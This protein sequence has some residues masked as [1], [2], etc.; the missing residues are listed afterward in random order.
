M[1]KPMT[2]TK[3]EMIKV[4]NEEIKYLEADLRWHREHNVYTTNDEKIVTIFKAIKAI[5][6]EYHANKK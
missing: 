3:S 5:V 6:E 2:P 1:S 4:L